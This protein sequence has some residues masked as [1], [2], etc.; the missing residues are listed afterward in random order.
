[1]GIDHLTWPLVSMG[2][3][4]SQLQLSS[5]VTSLAGCPLCSH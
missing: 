3:N 5:A 4:N 2:F 1:M